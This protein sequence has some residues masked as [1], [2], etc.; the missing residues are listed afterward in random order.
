MVRPTETIYAKAQSYRTMT[1]R[2]YQTSTLVKWVHCVCCPCYEEPT[3]HWYREEKCIPLNDGVVFYLQLTD[4]WYEHKRPYLPHHRCRFCGQFITY[5]DCYTCRW[6]S[7]A[8][9]DKC[10]HMI[11]D[12]PAKET[13][14]A[15][16]KLMEAIAPTPYHQHSR[17]RR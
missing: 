15:V 6:F 9:D 5:H 11:D 3:D 12:C 2:A 17:T 13:A 7:V 8:Y 4:M 16:F 1:H 10:R 14:R